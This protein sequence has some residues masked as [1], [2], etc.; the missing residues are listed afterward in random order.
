MERDEKIL[1]EGGHNFKDENGKT[2]FDF[3]ELAQALEK[4]EHLKHAREYIRYENGKPKFDLENFFEKLDDH[5]EE[6]EEATQDLDELEDQPW[7]R[8]DVDR[9]KKLFHE[10]ERAVSKDP[11]SC[12]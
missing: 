1:N 4:H 8:E 3:E 9:L 11:T 5:A 6:S 7:K 10:D 2:K 12:K